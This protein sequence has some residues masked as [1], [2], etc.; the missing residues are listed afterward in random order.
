MLKYLSVI[1]FTTYFQML[2]HKKGGGGKNMAKMLITE[3]TYC[4]IHC[5]F[6]TF[7]ETDIFHNKV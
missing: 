7:H 3:T 4:S 5:I 6:L 2:T 1:V